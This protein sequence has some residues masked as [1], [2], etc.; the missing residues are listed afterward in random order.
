MKNR[1]DYIIAGA[2]CSGLS[3]LLRMLRQPALRDKSILLLDKAPKNTNDRTW[4]FWEQE[5]GIFE[6]IVHH[7]WSRLEFRSNFLQR[8]LQ[9]DP[10]QYK[11]IRGLDFYRHC[12]SELARHPNVE[13]LH[14]AVHSV[15]TETDNAYAGTSDGRFY[16][17]YL[18][19]GIPPSQIAVPK[20]KFILLQHFK[21]WR[22]RTDRPCFD[23]TKARLMDFT[24]SQSAGPAF[25]YLLPFTENEALIEYTLF[26]PQVLES[27]E[28]EIK[29]EEYVARCCHSGGYAILEQE[30]GVIPMT[31]I[32]FPVLDG[33]VINIGT[34]GGRVKPSSGYAFRSIQKQADQ[35]IDSLLAH[36]DP[37]HLPKEPVKHDFYD[38]VF[39]NVLHQRPQEA[40]LV[41]SRMFAATAPKTIFRFLDNE[42]TFAEDLQVIGSLRSTAFVKAGLSELI[43]KATM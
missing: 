17:D 27:R 33:R 41:F 31:N 22:I 29:L 26:S 4:C 23:P 8:E 10:Y 42:S 40:P 13:V 9:T 37:V 15:G 39:L 3:L 30:F 19:N 6:P 28:Y 32:S 1:Y 21:G 24:T 12:F 43:K 7:R 11:M 16:S 35:I 2:G 18:F 34:A 36:G 14:T 20:N 5:P 25:F 38:S